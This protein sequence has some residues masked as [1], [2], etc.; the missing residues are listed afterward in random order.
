LS[1][2][3]AIFPGVIGGICLILAFFALQTLPVNYA[4]IL[5]IV[6]AI[7]FFIMEMKITSYGLLSVAGVVSLLLGSMMLFRGS[8]PDMR[9]SWTVLLPTLTLVSGFFVV[10]AGL[11]FRAQVSK[12]ATGSKGLLGEIGLVKKA[13]APEGKVFVHGELWNATAKERIEVN[14][15]VR[16]VN[17][18]GL[19]L[20]VEPAEPPP[21]RVSYQT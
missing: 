6:L 21:K 16:V 2:P 20:E 5:L 15:K 8:S 17:V 9:L 18:A 14:T 7:I 19:I 12:P 10:I 1:H 3:G 11:V 4:G 13:L